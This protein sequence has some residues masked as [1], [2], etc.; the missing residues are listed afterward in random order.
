MEAIANRPVILPVELNCSTRSS[1]GNGRG[2]LVSRGS[3]GLCG[4]SDGWST[5]GV[6]VCSVHRICCRIAGLTDCD[7]QDQALEDV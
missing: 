5:H 3:L 7:D 6:G 4:R 2:A 1:V